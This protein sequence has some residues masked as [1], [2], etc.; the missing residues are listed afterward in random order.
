MGRFTPKDNVWQ[1]AG[2][3]YV[4]P[5]RPQIDPAGFDSVEAVEN[6]RNK[7]LDCVKEM[8]EKL[9][10][11]VFT[12]GLTE[13]WES[14]E[15]GSIYPLAPGVAGGVMDPSIHR[16]RNFTAKEVADDLELFLL[17]LQSVN[18]KARV[19]LTVSPVPL[20]A[21]YENRHVLVSNTHSKAVL[22]TVA[23][24]TA[25]RYEHCDYFPSYEIITGQHVG[26]GYLEDD[27][28][29]VRPEGVDHVMRVFLKHYAGK[30][31]VEHQESQREKEQKAAIERINDVICDEEAIDS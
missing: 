30:E 29:S 5:F 15:D 9:D 28:R 16:F 27:L 10:I 13:S 23:G 25:T 26:N 2:G 1:R 4:D 20:I 14:L 18:P 19:I 6:S 3:R 11:L 17:K 31:V 24:E 21:T 7:H 22:R 8:F 12:L